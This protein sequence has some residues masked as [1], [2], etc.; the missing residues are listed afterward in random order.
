M[1]TE[2]CRTGDIAPGGLRPFTA[3]GRQVIV[4]N[5]NGR[6]YAV[7]CSCAHRGASFGTGT[8]DGYILTCPLHFAQ[9]DITTGQALSGPLPPDPGHP[10]GN[11]TVYAVRIENEKVF[12]DA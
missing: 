10:T 8:L 5:Y 11:L 3:A 4:G 7:G 9:F 2:V 12:I 1:L 6:F